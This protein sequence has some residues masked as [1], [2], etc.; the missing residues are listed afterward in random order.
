MSQS[1]SYKA[2][3]VALLIFG[4]LYLTLGFAGG[5]PAFRYAGPTLAFF[6]IVLLVQAKRRG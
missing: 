1:R 4:A 5:L 6:G 3:G 2:V